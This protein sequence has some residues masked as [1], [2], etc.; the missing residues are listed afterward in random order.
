MNAKKRFWRVLC[1]VAWERRRAR[2]IPPKSPFSKAHS[3]VQPPTTRASLQLLE[4]QYLFHGL[5]NSPQ[6]KPIATNSNYTSAG[7]PAPCR[8]PFEKVFS[9]TDYQVGTPGDFPFMCFGRDTWSAS[10]TCHVL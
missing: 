3:A 6:S 5:P 4:Q 10:D 1:M 8:R 9:K 2:T 7:E